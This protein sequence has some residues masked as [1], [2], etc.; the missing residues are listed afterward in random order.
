MS[1]LLAFGALWWLFGNPFVA[2]LVMLAIVYFLER[3]YIGLTP[4]FV[5]PLKRRSAIARWR[6]HIQMSP[7]DVSAKIE[8]ARLLIERRSY[9]EARE[10]LSGIETQMEIGRAHV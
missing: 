10:I 6:R 5:R 4:S 1:K 2:V 9:A 8:L 7:H 3:R